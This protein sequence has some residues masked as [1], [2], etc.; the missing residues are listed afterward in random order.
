MLTAALR[1]LGLD[2]SYAIG[3]DLRVPGSGGHHGLVISADDGT[4]QLSVRPMNACP[5]M[6]HPDSATNR[7][8][9]TTS[10]E[11]ITTRP[12]TPRSGLPIR[13]THDYVRNGITLFAALEVATGKVTDACYQRH[14][15]QEFLEFLKQVA[16]AYPRL[17]LH[18][19]CDNYAT[20]KHEAVRKW[21]ARNKRMTLHFTPPRA[22]G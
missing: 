16:R 14:R 11:S 3:A 7:A 12:I 17:E 8:P 13:R 6:R 18:V 15:H 22:A 10:R 1:Q 19:V 4:R 9:P 2:P 5:S 20:H 21:L